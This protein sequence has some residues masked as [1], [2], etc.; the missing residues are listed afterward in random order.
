MPPCPNYNGDL[1]DAA[2]RRSS[3]ERTRHYSWVGQ[4][5]DPFF[6]DLRVFDLLYGADLS[7]PATTRCPG[8]NVKHVRAAGPDERTS[9]RGGES[10][11][12]IWSTAIA[13][14]HA[15]R[16]RRRQPVV[17]GQERPGLTPG[18][19]ARERGRRARGARRTTSTP[20]AQ[21]RRR[22]RCRWSRTLRLPHLLNAVYGTR[23]CRT[24]DP[25]TA[26]IQR[27]T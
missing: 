2:T 27:R 18:Q 22:R 6:L 25:D 9:P 26:G 3:A 12:G 1:F 11:I 21:G 23:R 14:E 24:P 15:D 16:E 7:R 8:F 5:D 4:S 13:S 17:P 20:P 10:T 19:P